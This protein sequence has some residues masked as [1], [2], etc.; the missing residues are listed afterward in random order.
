MSAEDG[1]AEMVFASI[2][3]S[4]VHDMKNSLST[5]I[6]AL[7]DLS[8]ELEE[9]PLPGNQLS[10]I[11]YETKRLNNQ[12]IVLLTLYK[13]ENKQYQLNIDEHLVGEFLHDAL[14]PYQ[15]LLNLHHINIDVQCAANL[16]WYFDENLISGVIGNII[17]NSQ[18]YTKDAILIEATEQDGQLCI[19]VSDNG[20]GYPLELL[21]QA[22]PN[23]KT[24]SFQTGSTGLGLYFAESIAELHK[25]KQ[26]HGR[27]SIDNEGING[28]SRFRLF[29]P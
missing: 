15:E 26:R 8:T 17:G 7:D 25:N 21:S 12:L 10:T 2:L 28:G 14:L 11:R 29:L 9:Q 16:R 5:V 20:P 6:N 13:L 18:R 19:A 27:I 1:N 3:A 4:T 23:K 24:M 22:T